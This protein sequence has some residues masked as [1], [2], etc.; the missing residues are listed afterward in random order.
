MSNCTN[1]QTEARKP[2][3]IA[4]N[5]A[6]AVVALV[7]LG[8]GCSA[9]PIVPAEVAQPAPSASVPASSAP[10]PTKSTPAPSKAAPRATKAEASSQLDAARAAASALDTEGMAKALGCASHEAQD[11]SN[12]EGFTEGF[13]CDLDGTVIYAFHL[14]SAEAAAKANGL[15]SDD[16]ASSYYAVGTWVLYGPADFMASFAQAFEA[17]QS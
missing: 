9:Q 2:R 17:G 14:D 11:V 15:K 8:A 13:I 5:T 16:G 7:A 1:H 3:H 12:R 6:L 10:T 4:R